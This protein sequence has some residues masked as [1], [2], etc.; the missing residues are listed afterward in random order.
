M[1]SHLDQ[2]L[3]VG[4]QRDAARKLAALLG[5]LPVLCGFEGIGH[6]SGLRPGRLGGYR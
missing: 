3:P 2:A 5:A 6:L 1:A 4:M